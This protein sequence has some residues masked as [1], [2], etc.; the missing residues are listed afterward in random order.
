MWKKSEMEL[1]QAIGHP[2]TNMRARRCL[3]I[4]TTQAVAR[5]LAV[6]SI[7]GCINGAAA[8]AL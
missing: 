3:Y 5:E 7:T 8:E 1:R 2:K 4:K 6:H